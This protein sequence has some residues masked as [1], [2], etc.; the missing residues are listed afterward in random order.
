M[1]QLAIGAVAIW[2]GVGTASGY[3]PRNLAQ[4]KNLA[5]SYGLSD[6]GL[7][8]SADQKA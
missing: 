3:G 4:S 5:G 8:P 7:S 2:G 6:Q 1:M